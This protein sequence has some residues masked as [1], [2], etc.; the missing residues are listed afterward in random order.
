MLERELTV[1]EGVNLIAWGRRGS[2]MLVSSSYKA[3]LRGFNQ[4]KAIQGTG[5]TRLQAKQR[6]LKAERGRRGLRRAPVEFRLLVRATCYSSCFACCW[7]CTA[8]LSSRFSALSST[9]SNDTPHTNWSKGH[10]VGH[11]ARTAHCTPIHGMHGHV[12]RL[13][14]VQ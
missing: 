12:L 2:C 6:P 3:M 11:S 9:S 14:V 1:D 13:H 7:C 10:V 8:Q 4:S 5:Q